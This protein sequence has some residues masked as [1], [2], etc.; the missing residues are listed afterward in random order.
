MVQGSPV[1]LERPALSTPLL[2]MLKLI[3]FRAE[4]Y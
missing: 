4:G 2:P 1:A 3:F